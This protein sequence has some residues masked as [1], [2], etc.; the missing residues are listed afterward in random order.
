MAEREKDKRQ[1]M[2]D[3]EIDSGKRTKSVK[4]VHGVTD[5]CNS[6]TRKRM[7]KRWRLPDAGGGNREAD[8]RWCG[9]LCRYV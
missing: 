6:D 7:R 9:A 1:L 3:I 4:V 8:G 5:R 2:V